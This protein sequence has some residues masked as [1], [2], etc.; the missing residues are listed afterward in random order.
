M[1]QPQSD[2][3]VTNHGSIFTLA[4]ETPAARDWVDEWLPADAMW[5]GSAVVV[6]HRYIE[7]I[8]EGIINDGLTVH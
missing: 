6:E 2:F 8:V 5:H 4:P 7:D 1:T 3:T